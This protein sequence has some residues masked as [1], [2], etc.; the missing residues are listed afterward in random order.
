MLEIFE[1]DFG[2]R[3]SVK[4]LERQLVADES[5]QMTPASKDV[6]EILGLNDTG[7]SKRLDAHYKYN[8]GQG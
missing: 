2:G 3:I 4:E 8:L 5:R 1:R 7:Y 6:F